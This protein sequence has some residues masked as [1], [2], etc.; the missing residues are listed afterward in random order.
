MKEIKG[1]T[2]KDIHATLRRL[3][4]EITFHNQQIAGHRVEIAR[5]QEARLVLMRIAEAD[6]AME[7][8][9]R[10][11]RVG[12]I[13][14]AHARPELIVRRDT[15]GE[16]EEEAKAA[17][18]EKWRQ[19]SQARR[20]KKNGSNANANTNTKSVTANVRDRV[21]DLL[22]D[23]PEGMTQDQIADFFGLLRDNKTRKPLANALYQMRHKGEIRRDEDY[24]Y[25]MASTS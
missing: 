3:D 18:R 12:V 11:E 4:E 5:A 25:R 19:A 6:M 9:A 17:L 21:R 14:G 22:K 8:M 15:S 10:Q 20:D 7:Q 24:H 13:D 1:E 16:D 2:M 23:K